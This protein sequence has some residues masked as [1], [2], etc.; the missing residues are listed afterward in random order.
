M[1]SDLYSREID[2]HRWDAQKFPTHGKLANLR[3][4]FNGAH[5]W[6]DHPFAD[7]LV[8]LIRPG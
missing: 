8:N 7:L 1:D 5:A 6:C 4:W 3:P 2:P